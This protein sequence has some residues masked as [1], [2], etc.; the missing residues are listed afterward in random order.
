MEVSSDQVPP[1]GRPGDDDDVYDGDDAGPR[2]IV[3]VGPLQRM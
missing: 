3:A 1:A 2:K